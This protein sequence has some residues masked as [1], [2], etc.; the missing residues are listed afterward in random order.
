MRGCAGDFGRLLRGRHAA[1]D[2]ALS[3]HFS[4]FVREIEQAAA[5]RPFRHGRR[6][7]VSMPGSWRFARHHL[8]M[9]QQP[10]GLA[11]E[12]GTCD[13]SPLAS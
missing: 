8:A 9:W 13:G 6:P 7:V 11:A 4:R 12:H 2:A 5:E 1:R 3:R 10:N